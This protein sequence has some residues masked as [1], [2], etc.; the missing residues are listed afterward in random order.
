[1]AATHKVKSGET[2]WSISKQHLGAGHLWPAIYIH[3]NS[4]EVVRKRGKRLVN[5]NLIHPGDV[6]YLPPRKHG[7][8]RLRISA[9][10]P[11]APSTTKPEDP[12]PATS[13]RVEKV[14]LA[15]RSAGHA[16]NDN[17]AARVFVPDIPIKYY[18]PDQVIYSAEITGW[19]ITAKLVGSVMLQRTRKVPMVVYSN[20]GAEL[21]TKTEARYALSRLT[22]ESKVTFDPSTGV[23]KFEC[24]MTSRAS[25]DAPGAKVTFIVTPNG[26][27]IGRASIAMP[28][29]KGFVGL[30]AFVS[31][32]LRADLEIESTDVNRN[33]PPNA[34]VKIASA[35][36]ATA[37]A[38]QPTR[39]HPGAGGP[40]PMPPSDGGQGIPAGT[41]LMVGA[42]FLVGV[43]IVQDL[44]TAGVGIADNAA[45][46]GMA[47]A[48]WRAGRAA[49]TERQ[50]VRPGA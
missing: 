25:V 8:P 18:F 50:R 38:S 35:P 12:K 45:A 27:R 17:P 20:K 24:S 49:N 19:K 44:A 3:N 37:V 15:T 39:L 47:A 22:A 7:T 46:I 32:D 34:A 33:L 11:P 41:W 31:G 28:T 36:S 16:A 43:M 42:A 13:N 26:T 6:I 30:F 10:P 48:M 23:A 5:P 29:L 2:L 9:P 4:P 14:P 1:M 21:A 40:P